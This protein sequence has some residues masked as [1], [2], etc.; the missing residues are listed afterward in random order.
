[1]KILLVDDE[2]ELVSALAQRLGFRGYEADWA[3][4][5]EEGLQ[6]VKD[7]QYD[8]AILDMKMPKYSG[9]DLQKMMSEIRPDMKFIFLSGHG[10]EDDYIEGSSKA[11]CYL[12]K[13][14]C[15]DLLLEKIKAVQE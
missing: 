13:P 2:I 5:G 14:I 4:T 7:N 9:L 11:E 12:M 15:I 1:M 8:L 10:S 3:A 6:K